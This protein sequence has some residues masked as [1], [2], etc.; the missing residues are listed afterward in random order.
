MSGLDGLDWH[1]DW[2]RVRTAGFSCLVLVLIREERRGNGDGD[3][4]GVVGRGGGA[5]PI[6]LVGWLLAFDFGW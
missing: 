4:D 3:G 5:L 2:I 1:C 6:I